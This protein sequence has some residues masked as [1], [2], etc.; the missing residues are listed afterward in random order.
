[1]DNSNNAVKVIGALLLG[2]A[3]GGALGML[4]APEKGSLTRKKIASKA[5]DLTD[6]LKEKFNDFLADA[7]DEFENTKENAKDKLKEYTKE[8]AMDNGGNGKVK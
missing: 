1:M 3:I 5:D 4:F 2:A 8:Y 7:K 6:A